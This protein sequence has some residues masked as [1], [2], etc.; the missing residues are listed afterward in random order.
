MFPGVFICVQ[1][2]VTAVER[3]ADS[4]TITFPLPCEQPYSPGQFL[5]MRP[6]SPTPTL[7][8]YF[9]CFCSEL[10][11]KNIPSNVQNL[12]T[13]NVAKQFW[14]IYILTTYYIKYRQTWMSMSLTKY[15]VDTQGKTNDQNTEKLRSVKF[16][17]IKHNNVTVEKFSNIIL[18]TTLLWII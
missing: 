13:W 14:C 1:A 15:A 16:R 12:T 7:K 6:C 17:N 9:P 10:R 18:K 5:F 8:E 4:P 11:L 3:D 2:V